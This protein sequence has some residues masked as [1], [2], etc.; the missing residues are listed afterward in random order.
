M[1]KNVIVLIIII[2]ILFGMFITIYNSTKS[3]LKV[4]FYADNKKINVGQEIILQ[5]KTNKQIIATNFEL[6]YNTE[7]FELIGSET[8]N[9]MVSKKN[10]KIACIYAD[11]TGKGIDT[12]KLRL[13][14]IKETKAN[15]EITNSKFREVDKEESYVQD[16]IQGINKKIKIQV[17]K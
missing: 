6:I 14:A 7:S 4:D 13:K 17:I 11:I 10:D 2:V 16:Q 12:F 15:F 9:F 3:K 5:I 1:K 8:E